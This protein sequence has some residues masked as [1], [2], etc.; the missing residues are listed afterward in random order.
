[1]VKALSKKLCRFKNQKKYKIF[2]I[3]VFLPFLASPREAVK[4]LCD[5]EFKCF[6]DLSQGSSMLE[7]M[8]CPMSFAT[9]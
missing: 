7:N 9:D 3:F 4:Q 1:M 2:A 6:G 5:S 8:R